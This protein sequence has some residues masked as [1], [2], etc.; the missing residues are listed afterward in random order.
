MILTSLVEL[1]AALITRFQWRVKL[2]VV[3][4]GQIYGFIYLFICFRFNRAHWEHK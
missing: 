3:K 2:H 1:K 4:K